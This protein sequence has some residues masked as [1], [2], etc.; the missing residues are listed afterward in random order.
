M[1]KH[2]HVKNGMKFLIHAPTSMVNQ[3]NHHWSWGRG[4]K[5][6][7]I[8]FYPR[9]VL[10]FGYCRCLRV[11]VCLSINHQLVRAITHQ[12]FKLESQNLDQRCKRPWLRSL[13]FLGW[14]TLN[15]KVKSYLKVKIYPSLSLSVWSPPTEV[16]I[17][18]FGPKMHLST[19][20]VPI[21]FGLDWPWCSV[22]FLISNLLFYQNL[23]LIIHL[24]QFVYI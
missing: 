14:L 7:P 20:K 3:L 15:F 17:S 11:C 9:P 22:S 19:V 18:K 21:D 4:D 16:S 13:C 5:F 10:A 6:G 23:H 8:F 2:Y 12:P 1:W 24:H